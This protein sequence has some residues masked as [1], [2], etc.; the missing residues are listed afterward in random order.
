[1]NAAP[2]QDPT[3]NA[4]AQARHLLE[5]ASEA[6]LLE[7]GLDLADQPGAEAHGVALEAALEQA[8]DAESTE[9]L[10]AAEIALTSALHEAQAAGLKVAAELDELEVEGVLGPSRMRVLSAVIARA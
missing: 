9:E 4:L 10:Q 5:L 6:R 7:L 1:M 8:M 2:A 3:T